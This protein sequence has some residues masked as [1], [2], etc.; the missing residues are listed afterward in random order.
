[1]C[2]AQTD[3]EYLV[4]TSCYDE[5][6]N[7]LDEVTTDR[8]KLQEQLEKTDERYTYYKDLVRGCDICKAKEVVDNL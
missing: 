4:C 5:I 7:K 1:M 8:D 3:V 6:Q 2:N